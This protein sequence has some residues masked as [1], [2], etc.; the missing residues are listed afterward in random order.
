M[1]P[2]T[3]EEILSMLPEGN[4]VE[5]APDSRDFLHE[6]VF[7]APSSLPRRVVYENTLSQ[8]QNLPNDPTTKYACVFYTMTHITNEQN[9]LEWRD[10]PA[11]EEVQAFQEQSAALQAKQAY[12][13]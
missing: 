8:N 5:D 2:M 1:E 6:D 7:G 3:E 11:W 4:A 12:E 9:F 13:A 10:N